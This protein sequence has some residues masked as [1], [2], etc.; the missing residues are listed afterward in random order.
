MSDEQGKWHNASS[1]A[2]PEETGIRWTRTGRGRGF[3]L[4]LVLP[5]FTT[6]SRLVFSE[7]VNREGDG[8]KD[9]DAAMGAFE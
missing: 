7:Y 2:T 5:F 4:G 6:A 3:N 9:N 1:S 8:A